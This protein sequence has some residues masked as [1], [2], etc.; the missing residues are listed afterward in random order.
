MQVT[1]TNQGTINCNGGTTTI[2]AQASFG[3]SNYIYSLINTGT[4]AVVQGP[5]GPQLTP[6][7]FNGVAAGTYII[8][9]NSGNCSVDS[10]VITI[11]QPLPLTVQP[12]LPTT[13]MNVKCFNE[14]TGSYNLVVTG[15]TGL[16][17]YAINTT[18]PLQFVH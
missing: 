9:V 6:V 3:L 1:I 11:L 10:A 15:G 4:N 17:Q 13:Q 8:R 2:S 5:V 14:Q 18:S 16:I 7:T 12:P